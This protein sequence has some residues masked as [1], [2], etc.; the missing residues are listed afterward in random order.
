MFA[1]PIVSRSKSLQDHAPNSD[2]L[3]ILTGRATRP[4]LGSGIVDQVVLLTGFVL[5]T[6]I[7]V[8]FL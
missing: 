4:I 1:S 7:Y 2:A 8:F 6:Y 5:D 3:P